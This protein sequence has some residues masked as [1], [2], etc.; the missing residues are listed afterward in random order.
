M[1]II[2]KLNA[3]INAGLVEMKLSTRL[4]DLG[5]TPLGGSPADFAKLIARETERWSFPLLPL[6]PPRREGGGR[7]GGSRVIRTSGIKLN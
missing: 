7:R 5:S 1:D 6:L 2:D 3:E 4:D